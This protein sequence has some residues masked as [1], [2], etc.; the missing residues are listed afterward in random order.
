[1]L[2]QIIT[3]IITYYDCEI[4]VRFEVQSNQKGYAF[5]L[6][7]MGL[8]RLIKFYLEV[9]SSRIGIKRT[10]SDKKRQEKF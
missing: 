1:M 4:V 10:K 3:L 6:N 9:L 5:E 2:H 8:I 7:I